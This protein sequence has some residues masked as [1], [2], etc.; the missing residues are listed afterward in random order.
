MKWPTG[1]MEAYLIFPD[2]WIEMYGAASATG[3]SIAAITS[4]GSIPEAL[5]AEPALAWISA[6]STCALASSRCTLLRLPVKKR[7]LS[8]DF[9]SPPFVWG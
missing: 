6:R 7:R 4:I 1:A 3:P 5:K 9:M 8:C 2:S